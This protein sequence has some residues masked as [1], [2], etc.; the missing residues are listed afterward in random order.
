M[1]GI[2]I[3]IVN[4]IN[5]SHHWNFSFVLI[6]NLETQEDRNRIYKVI[7]DS[8]PNEGTKNYFSRCILVFND[9]INL[10][11]FMLEFYRNTYKNTNPIKVLN[12]KLL[13]VTY[14]DINKFWYDIHN[15]W[16]S[17]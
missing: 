15:S 13:F 17:L 4:A 9:N 7:Y 16:D 12:E 10:E 14:K 3:F 11:E 8:V 1:Y 5:H 6:P 2:D